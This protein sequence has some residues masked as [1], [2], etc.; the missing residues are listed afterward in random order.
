MVLKRTKAMQKALAKRFNDA[1]I[2][3]DCINQNYYLDLQSTNFQF[4]N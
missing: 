2:L 1:T 4:K 3:D